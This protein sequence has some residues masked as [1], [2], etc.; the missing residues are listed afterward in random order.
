MTAQIKVKSA[1]E[2]TYDVVSLGEVMLRL[3]PGDRR[4]HTT[5]NFAASEGGGE[6]NVARG[7]R[8]AFGMRSA[9]LTSLVKNE[10]G[11]LVE[12]LI[13][14]GGVD[15]KFI[16]WVESDGIGHAARNGINFTERGFGVRG[17]VGCSDRAHTAISQM[18]AEDIDLDY[19]F[20]ELGVR[21][22]H[23]GGVYAALSEQSS[24]T[25]IDI[26]KKAKEHGT[27]VSYDLNWRP[28]LWNLHGGKERAQEVNREIARYVDVMIGNE[29]D[30]TACLGLEIEGANEHLDN[31]EVDA[32]R[33]MIE[34]ATKEFPNFKAIGTTMRQVRTASINDWGA[35][36]WA[37]GQGFVQARQRD[38]LE[39]YDRVGGGDSFASGVI[40]GLMEYGDIQKG[41]ELGAANGA[42]AMTTPGDTTMATLKEI[43]ALAAGG[44]ARVR[45]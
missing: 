9:I 23:T 17:A 25:C 11:M 34:S 24:Q 16:H 19:L 15:T 37:A 5:R 7:F 45:R 14:N 29:E 10:V 21:W 8:R 13:L 44:S 20:G 32:F 35:V 2:T 43:E 39:I 26:V 31:L 1:E 12:D 18:K 38:N 6:Y 42:L 4:I 30:F 28:S 40:Y 3:D 33:R 41:V 36:G 22:L 27:M